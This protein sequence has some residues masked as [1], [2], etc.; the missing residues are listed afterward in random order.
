MTLAQQARTNGFNLNLG[1][2]GRLVRFSTGEQIRVLINENPILSEPGPEVG[3][4]QVPVYS[5]IQALASQVSNPRIVRNMIESDDGRTFAGRRHTVIRYDETA[6]DQ[7]TY[8]WTV[9]SSRAGAVS[10]AVPIT[11]T[12]RL[13]D[14]QG[15]VITDEQGNRITV[16]TI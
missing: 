8:R 7:V 1:V 14:E 13:T 6:T 11:G 16:P 2:R 3:K 15:N 5:L 10:G 9:E 12:S 4:S